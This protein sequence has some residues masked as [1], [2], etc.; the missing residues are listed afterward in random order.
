MAKN[1]K[2]QAAA[3]RFGPAVKTFL[4]CLLIGGAGVGYVSQKNKIQLL[5]EQMKKLETRREKLLRDRQGLVRKLTMLKSGR[6]LETQVRR[7]NLDLAP[8]SPDRVVRLSVTPDDVATGRVE[9]LYVNQAVPISGA[10]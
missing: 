7:M 2:A 9:R 1:R 3:V 8:A 6:E 5:S 10:R 4:L